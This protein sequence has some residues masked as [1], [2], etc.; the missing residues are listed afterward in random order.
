MPRKK[1]RMSKHRKEQFS[2]GMELL[3]NEQTLGRKLSQ[4]MH[5]AECSSTEV[6]RHRIQR[7]FE[8]KKKAVKG[9]SETEATPD[10]RLRT[11]KGKDIDPWN[12]DSVRMT[13]DKRNI[14]MQ[15]VALDKY[16]EK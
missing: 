13:T 1:S 7:H 4:A 11:A 6:D 15:Q 5:E 16:F 2:S 12:W 9:Q 10:E 14:D 3:V 8:A